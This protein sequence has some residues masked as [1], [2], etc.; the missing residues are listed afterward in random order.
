[1]SQ[2]PSTDPLNTPQFVRE[3]EAWY[4]A[5]VGAMAGYAAVAVFLAGVIAGL[6]SLIFDLGPYQLAGSIVAGAW[7]LIALA[8]VF[9]DVNARRVAY[10][11]GVEVERF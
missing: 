10:S 9:L 3:R 6:A 2:P 1:M 11:G 5:G 4:K 7:A 8:S